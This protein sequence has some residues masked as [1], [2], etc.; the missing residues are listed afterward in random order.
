VSDRPFPALVLATGIALLLVQGA[1]LWNALAG[2]DFVTRPGRM[3]LVTTLTGRAGV[4][5]LADALLVG[6]ALALRK[7]PLFRT[8]AGL[9][10]VAAAAVL[11]AATFVLLDAGQLAPAVV[12][13]EVAAYRVLIV[14]ILGVL[15]TVGTG[16][17]L[18]A[19]ALARL[20][21]APPPGT[22]AT[23]G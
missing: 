6:A 8:L 4:L 7:P 18:A 1:D 15:L 22:G 16:A 14:R 13:G 12:A 2:T 3:G 21:E 10:W 9:H 11:L 5:L 17:V 19:R 20:A 23:G